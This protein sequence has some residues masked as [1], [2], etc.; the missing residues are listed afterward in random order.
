MPPS[1]KS[2]A[3]P[4]NQSLTVFFNFFIAT[5]ARAAQKL[6]QV[7]EQVKITWS[8]FVLMC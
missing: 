1:Q 6:L 4:L 8:L 3:S 2:T 7:C 5:H